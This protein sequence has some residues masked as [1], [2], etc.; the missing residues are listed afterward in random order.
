MKYLIFGMSLYQAG[1]IVILFTL[2]PIFLL[3]LSADDFLSNEVHLFYAYGLSKIDNSTST[4]TTTSIQ[5]MN[6]SRIIHLKFVGWGGPE[7]KLKVEN[8]GTIDSFRVNGTTGNDSAG[9][10]SFPHYSGKYISLTLGNLTKKSDNASIKLWNI[11][12]TFNFVIIGAHGQYQLTF[13]NGPLSKHGW[14][15]NNYYSKIDAY[16]TRLINMEHLIASHGD[17]YSSLYK[18]FIVLQKYS[19]VSPMDFSINFFDD[20]FPY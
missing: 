17:K 6:G 8:L 7:N 14:N 10:T 18:L 2:L 1:L 5:N 13:V 20:A 15:G 11:Q 9:F 16:S 3:L 19:I 4:N 12:L